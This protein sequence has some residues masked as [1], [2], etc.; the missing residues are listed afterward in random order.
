MLSLKEILFKLV[1]YS[2]FNRYD[3]KLTIDDYDNK[4]FGTSYN[5]YQTRNTQ[6]HFTNELLNFV[7]F[8][9]KGNLL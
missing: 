7:E 9:F 2:L 3:I 8:T 6:F 5:S 4:N 1:Y